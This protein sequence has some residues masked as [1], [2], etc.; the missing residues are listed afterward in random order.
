MARSN[1]FESVLRAGMDTVASRRTLREL[2]AFRTGPMLDSHP[3]ARQGLAKGAAPF[4]EYMIDESPLRCRIQQTLL[5]DS[6][7]WHDLVFSIAQFCNR[8]NS[9]TTSQTNACLI[10]ATVLGPSGTGK[11]AFKA[12]HVSSLDVNFDIIKHTMRFHEALDANTG[13]VISLIDEPIGRFRSANLRSA[14][15]APLTGG[16]LRWRQ[17]SRR[18]FV[19]KFAVADYHYLEID[20]SDSDHKKVPVPILQQMVVIVAN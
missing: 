2:S 5:F 16:L 11:K 10:R 13:Y 8:Q 14:A 4:F 17:H 7:S 18:K 20:R 12:R 6:M 19:K 1:L 3:L 9:F 15:L